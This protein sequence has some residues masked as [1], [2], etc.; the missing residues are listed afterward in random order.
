[1]ADIIACN[2]DRSEPQQAQGRDLLSLSTS[3]LT[4]RGLLPAQFSDR[5]LTLLSSSTKPLARYR[6]LYS[7]PFPAPSPDQP[8]RRLHD[9]RTTQG[10][11]TPLH[12]AG[13]PG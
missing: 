1:M 12:R 4:Y 7:K 8:P 6:Q 5:D 9:F 3:N 13:A 11:K 10:R 2:P